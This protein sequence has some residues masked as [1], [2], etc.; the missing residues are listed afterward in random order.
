MTS[1][2]TKRKNIA[3]GGGAVVLRI[4]FAT[5]MS[6]MGNSSNI[7]AEEFSLKNPRYDQVCRLYI[8][9]VVL[10]LIIPA[11]KISF[12]RRINRCYKLY[13]VI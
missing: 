6:A 13:E 9:I 12:G 3:R 7:T 5:K 1:F 10:V 2:F 4:L 8:I 11:E